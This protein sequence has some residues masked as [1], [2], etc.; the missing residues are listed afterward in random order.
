MRHNYPHH[1]RFLV[2]S[3]RVWS[4][5]NLTTAHPSFSS[6]SPA[7]SIY[8]CSFSFPPYLHLF[9]T[10][11]PHIP[12]PTYFRMIYSLFSVP[13]PS[14][15]IH[16]KSLNFLGGVSLGP[17]IISIYF[18]FLLPNG[19]PNLLICV[20]SSLPI[21]SVSAHSPVFSGN[22]YPKWYQPTCSQNRN[23]H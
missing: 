19:L 17:P 7:P 14:H 4:S 6:P 23:P 18:P 1:T 13:Q 15:L 16:F 20:H 12:T 21:T 11:G 8:P 10:H 5:L 9:S 22:I 2:L 3:K